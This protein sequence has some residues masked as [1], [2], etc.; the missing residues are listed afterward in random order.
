MAFNSW[1]VFAP[2][3]AVG[4]LTCGAVLAGGGPSASTGRADQVIGQATYRCKGGVRVHI[5]QMTS[6]AR[7][8]FAGQTQTL[9]LTPEASGVAYQNSDFSW[10]SKRRASYM[11]DVNT[12][13]LVLTDCVPVKS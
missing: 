5:T 9:D 1:R 6:S 2:A 10:F 11:K 13:N 7:V 12:G 8:D 4:L 3:L